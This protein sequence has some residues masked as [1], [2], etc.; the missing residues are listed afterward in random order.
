LRAP[1]RPDVGAA[2]RAEVLPVSLVVDDPD[3]QLWQGDALEMLRGLPSGS[4]HCAL[5]SPP[6]YSLRDYGCEGQIGLEANVDEWCANL[7][8][9]FRELRRVLRDDGTFWCEVGDGFASKQLV[10]APWR[11]A[12]A[13]QDDGW[14]LRSEIVWSK[15][16]PMPESVTDEV[17]FDGV[18]VGEAASLLFRR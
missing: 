8:A 14:I 4:V 16:N 10:G 2:L 7:V 9:V 1:V 5:T 18:P 17:S 12:F 6:F 11:L 13:L 3:F 15:D